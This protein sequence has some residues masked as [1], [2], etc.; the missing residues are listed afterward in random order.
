MLCAA[1]GKCEGAAE[2]LE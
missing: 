1:F 2:H